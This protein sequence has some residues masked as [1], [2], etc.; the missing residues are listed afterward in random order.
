MRKRINIDFPVAALASLIA[1]LLWFHVITEKEYT[2]EVDVPLTVDD[3]PQGLVLLS[4]PPPTVRLKIR[5]TGKELLKYNLGRA[6][7][8]ASVVAAN[9]ARGEMVYSLSEEDLELPYGLSLVEIFDGELRLD[10]DSRAKKS[11]RVRPRATGSPEEGYTVL[12]KMVEPERISLSGPET[13]MRHVEEV[14]TM[15]LDVGGRSE[16]F[17]VMAELVPP[18]GRGWELSPDSVVVE[19]VIQQ[20]VA[21][22]FDSVPVGIMNQPRRWGVSVAP[23]FIKLTLSGAESTMKELDVVQ[24]AVE[25]DVAGFRKGQHFLPARIK[26][27]DGVNLISASPKKFNVTIE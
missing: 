18:D 17:Q 11:V 3:Q 9:A 4:A 27:P 15:P 23:E 12:E 26:L 5:G 10:F 22:T 19:F 16:S 20:I 2:E 21:V 6:R 1:L 13:L 8:S 24:I 7:R 14:E 25:I